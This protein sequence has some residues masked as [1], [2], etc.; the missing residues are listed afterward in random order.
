MAY[1]RKVINPMINPAA[2]DML[3][4][5]LGLVEMMCASGFRV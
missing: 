3:A 4:D 5:R 1:Q 2:F